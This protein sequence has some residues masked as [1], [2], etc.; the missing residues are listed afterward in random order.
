M[1]KKVAIGDKS[2]THSVLKHFRNHIY[3]EFI[4][5]YHYGSLFISIQL[6]DLRRKDTFQNS[7]WVF[8]FCLPIHFFNYMFHG[9]EYRYCP[10]TI[11]RKVVEGNHAYR[12]WCIHK[13]IEIGE[14]GRLALESA[15]RYSFHLQGQYEGPYDRN[16]WPLQKKL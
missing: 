15:R 11:I 3:S 2:S 8:F 12:I 14:G 9:L 5:R 4:V 10:N 6:Y 16:D 1:E 13:N 7:W